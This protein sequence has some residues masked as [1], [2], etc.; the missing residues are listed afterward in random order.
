MRG[1]PYSEAQTRTALVLPVLQT[2]NGQYL[3]EEEQSLDGRLENPT[4]Q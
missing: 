3:W 1:I 2:E 4:V